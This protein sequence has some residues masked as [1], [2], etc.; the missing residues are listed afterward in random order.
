MIDIVI[1]MIPMKS[2]SSLAQ[3]ILSGAAEVHVSLAALSRQILWFTIE[4]SRKT[5]T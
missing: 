1:M 5:E 4:T 3:N 2:C